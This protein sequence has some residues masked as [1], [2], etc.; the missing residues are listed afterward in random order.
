MYV[1]FAGAVFGALTAAQQEYLDRVSCY[2]AAL[3]LQSLL[4]RSGDY[5]GALNGIYDGVLNKA[6]AAW[7]CGTG[8][9]KIP[10]PYVSMAIPVGPVSREFEICAGTEDSPHAFLSASFSQT[11]CRAYI[12]AR[13]PAGLSTAL[14]AGAIP[15]ENMLRLPDGSLPS[16][17]LILAWDK[18]YRRWRAGQSQGMPTSWPASP[19]APTPTSPGV[20]QSST[21]PVV[22]STPE[23]SESPPP[24]RR[25]RV[26]GTDPSTGAPVYATESWWS[27]PKGKA[28]AFT[29]GIV[30]AT[31]VLLAIRRSSRRSYGV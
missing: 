3:K 9:F 13:G 6:L 21:P 17:A 28:A 18:V 24:T 14:D 25:R 8:T 31:G 19:S 10:L 7:A 20:P 4:K 23:Q 12:E 22:P 16:P 1:Q 30:L 2:T 5:S 29:G 26:V 11:L 27:T 15:C